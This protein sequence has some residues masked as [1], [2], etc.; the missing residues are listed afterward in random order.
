MLISR[1]WHGYTESKNANAYEK[2]LRSE[3][4]PY[5][6]SKNITGFKGIQLMKKNLADETE[7][8]TIMWFDSWQAVKDFAGEDYENAVVPE[9]AQKLLKRYDAVSRHYE[10]LIDAA[11]NQKH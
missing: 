6:Q 9:A 4:F 10:V 5:I 1:I 8:I 3:I 7:F 2:L 11:S